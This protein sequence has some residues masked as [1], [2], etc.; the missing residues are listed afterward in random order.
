MAEPDGQGDEVLAAAVLRRGWVS[1]EQLAEAQNTVASLRAGGMPVTL[2]AFLVARGWVTAEQI[3]EAAEERP[4]PAQ[5]TRRLPPDYTYLGSV[6]VDPGV[7]LAWRVIHKATGRPGCLKIEVPELESS[8]SPWGLGREVVFLSILEDDPDVATLQTFKGEGRGYGRGYLVHDLPDG[9][10]LETVLKQEGRQSAGRVAWLGAKLARALDRMHRSD[11]IWRGLTPKRIWEPFGAMTLTGFT[12]ALLNAEAGEHHEEGAIAGTPAYLSPEALRGEVP[13]AALDRYALGVVLYEMATGSNPFKGGSLYD[14]VRRAQEL[15]PPPPHELVP[16]IPREVSGLILE[17]LTKDPARR[18]SELERV[19]GVFD[20][21]AVSPPPETRIVGK[22]PAGHEP[23]PEPGRSFRPKPST[24]PAPVVVRPNF[25][26]ID[27]LQDI[28]T[29]AAFRTGTRPPT[30]LGRL[31][32]PPRPAEEPGSIGPPLGYVAFRT[33]TGPRPAHDPSPEAVGSGLGAVLFDAV[34]DDDEPMAS[35]GPGSRGS[36]RRTIRSGS[37][38]GPYRVVDKIGQGAFGAVFLAEDTVSVTGRRVALKVPLRQADGE[39]ELALYRHEAKLWRVLSDTRHPNVLELFDVRPFDGV[40]TFVMEYVEGDDLHQVVRG[41]QKQDRPL[42][43]SEAVRILLD[44]LDALRVVHRKGIYHGDLKPSNVLIRREDGAVKVSDFSVSRFVGTSGAVD[45]GEVMGTPMYMAPEVWEGRP[46]LQSDI[47]ALGVLFYEV[48]TGRYPFEG[49]HSEELREQARRGSLVA[50]PSALRDEIPYE[51]ERVVLRCLAPDPA[52]RYAS[53]DHLAED[54]RA[55]DMGGDLVA[56]LADCVIDALGEE[57]RAFLQE[58]LVRKGYRGEGLRTL[59]L[60]YCLDEDDPKTVLTSCFS[61]AGLARMARGLGVEIGDQ[62][63]TPERYAQAILQRLGLGASET[64]TGLES[65]IRHLQDLEH[66]L[67]QAREFDAVASLVAQAARSFERVLQ[68]LVRFYG[69]FLYGR[70]YERSLARVARKR[71]SS[72]KPDLSKLTLGE[73]VGVL[74]ALND[75]L[76]GDSGEARHFRKVFRREFAVPPKLLADSRVVTVR[77]QFMHNHESVVSSGVRGAVDAA[78]PMIGEVL[79][80]LHELEAGQYHPRVVVVESFEVDRFGR[81]FVKCRTDQG[82]VEKVFT[83]ATIDPSRH[84][85]FHPT[86]NPTRIFP[87]I[88]P[89]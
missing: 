87:L 76:G 58:D 84:Y 47:F 3:R 19:A 25:E 77:N 21:F 15:N 48:I 53:V 16:E 72:A 11:V 9:P 36:S 74:Q 46:T 12:L 31:L 40:I 38:L 14:T 66:R 32:P 43:L 8:D 73:W 42:P 59:V 2:G 49:R 4:K 1:A 80:F 52:D 83:N 54:L 23:E 63:L 85:F 86:T 24:G 79:K 18:P 28:Q 56:R 55:T 10:N 6:D 33:R 37:M 22:T 78:R 71:L 41:R 75:H 57:D 61:K 81:K 62:Y 34:L 44:V 68:N 89:V 5:A 13:T 67:G 82:R 65:A 17:L 39:R 27:S 88:L 29:G 51:V 7:T 35:R 26:V 20:R 45:G 60:E 69:Q 30:S 64:P 70:F 50:P